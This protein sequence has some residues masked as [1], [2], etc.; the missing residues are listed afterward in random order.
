VRSHL[1]P[2]LLLLSTACE[3]DPAAELVDTAAGSAVTRVGVLFA[4]GKD[5]AYPGQDGN[6]WQLSAARRGTTGELVFE[7]DFMRMGRDEPAKADEV[8]GSLCEKMTTFDLLLR[9]DHRSGQQIPSPAETP[10][11]VRTTCHN[12]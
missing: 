10:D 7:E 9:V 4:G 3:I 1:V 12:D 2:I 8:L 6:V 11:P 5:A